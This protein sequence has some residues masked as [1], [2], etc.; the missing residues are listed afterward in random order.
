M[1]FRRR[2]FKIKEERGLTFEKASDRFGVNIRTLFRWQRNIE[3]KR[4][5][6]KP[7]TKIDMNKLRED[8][9]SHPDDFQCERAERFG[10]TQWGIGLA[11]RRL[12]ISYKKNTG[13]P[14]V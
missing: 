2:I 6:D 11:L 8:V 4:T 9:K 13:P 10:V 3:L 7:P 1:D 5:R 14:H 12:K